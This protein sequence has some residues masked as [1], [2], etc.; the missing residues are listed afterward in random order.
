MMGLLIN[1]AYKRGLDKDEEILKEVLTSSEPFVAA[2]KRIYA[3][4]YWVTQEESRRVYRRRGNRLRLG[5][6]WV[7]TKNKA[8]VS[9][10]VHQLRI[11]ASIETM[12]SSN[13]R[14]QVIFQIKTVTSGDMINEIE[15]VAYNLKLGQVKVVKTKSG[16]HILK[17]LDKMYHQ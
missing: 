13:E 3:D 6:V 5:H 14:E 7:K 4:K 10:I 16:Y 8:L 2:A 15:E 11:G 9:R 17:L 1:E 12:A